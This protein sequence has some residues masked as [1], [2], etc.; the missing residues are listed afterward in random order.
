MT[1]T[2]TTTSRVDWRD[3]LTWYTH[4]T[5]MCR[6][7]KGVGG[8]YFRA[9]AAVECVDFEHIPA[10][11]PCVVA[12]NHVSN[13]DVVYLG[14][15]LPRHPHFMAKVELYKNP[16]VA[17][18]IRMCGSFPVHRGENDAWAIQQAGRVLTGGQLLCMFPE[19]TRSKDKAQL[20]RGKVGAVKLALEYQTPL[21]PLAVTG[22]Y[23]FRVRGWRGHKIILQAGPPLD[24][25]ALAGPPPYQPNTLRELTALLMQRIAALLP[26]AQRGIYG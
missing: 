13:L 3:S 4:E 16:V 17:W 6:I 20:R 22:T 15:Y 1:E 25:A 8:L 18:G 19:G 23:D 10:A 12:S 9:V 2:A 21:I 7:I 11:G 14:L 26:P 5:M 24:V